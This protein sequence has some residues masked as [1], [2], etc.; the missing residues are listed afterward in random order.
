MATV[1]DSAHIASIAKRRKTK[2]KTGKGIV[3]NL[4]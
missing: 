3:K 2:A 1:T 4:K